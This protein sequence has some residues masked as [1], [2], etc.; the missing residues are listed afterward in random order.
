LTQ[1]LTDHQS[2]CIEKPYSYQE[3]RTL[4]MNTQ[5]FFLRSILVVAILAAAR[6]SLK[7]PTR[8]GSIF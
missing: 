3:P 7:P 5:R 8:P 1:L 6:L 4:S 2:M